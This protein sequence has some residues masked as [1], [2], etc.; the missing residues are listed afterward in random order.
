ME[1][2]IEQPPWTSVSIKSS[3]TKALW[4]KWTRLSLREGVLRRKF[5]DVDGKSERWQIFLPRVYRTESMTIAHR[6]HLGILKTAASIQSTAYWPTWKT[7]VVSF[8][9]TCEPCARYHRG[10]VRH[11]APMQ[12]PMVGEPWERA[13][14]DFTGHLA[15]TI[16]LTL[17]DNFSSGRK[18][19][20]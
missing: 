18:P 14:V 16:N 17:V 20:L 9:R 3:V 5:E 12:T 19:F 10:N 8:M 15:A 13:S 4:N 1:E 11:K 2:K 6:G 7:D